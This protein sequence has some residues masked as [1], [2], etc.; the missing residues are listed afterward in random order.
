MV[1]LHI[2]MGNTM[3]PVMTASCLKTPLCFLTASLRDDTSSS[4]VRSQCL[5]RSTL[6]LYSLF[7]FHEPTVLSLLFYSPRS[8]DRSFG[9]VP[10]RDLQ[11]AG[12]VS[13]VPP[14]V[15][16]FRH[17]SAII[18]HVNP[19]DNRLGPVTFLLFQMCVQ[20]R[21]KELHLL[22][23]KPRKIELLLSPQQ[24]KVSWRNLHTQKL[25]V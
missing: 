20:M 5:Y 19:G 25:P 4:L 9:A 2:T 10:P 21:G 14:R 6:S 11:E 8:T 23:R 13:P 1:T 3:R 18:S 12:W 16:L 17:R 7:S 24:S 15:P 22:P